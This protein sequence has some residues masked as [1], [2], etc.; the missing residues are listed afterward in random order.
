MAPRTTFRLMELY[1]VEL[2]SKGSHPRA[3]YAGDTLIQD[4]RKVQW[5]TDDHAEA[6]VL[7]PEELFNEE[8]VFN[9]QSLPETNGYGERAMDGVKVGDIVQLPRFGFC[10][11]YSPGTFILAHR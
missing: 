11:L 5:V 6:R 8:G 2:L 7:V 1:N 3:R 4:T 9:K 10:R